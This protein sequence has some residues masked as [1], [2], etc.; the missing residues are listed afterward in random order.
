MSYGDLTSAALVRF[1]GAVAGGLV[2]LAWDMRGL[3]ALHH[4]GTFL[5]PGALVGAVVG[6]IGAFRR[7]RIM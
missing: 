6:A 3:A 1:L 2:V 4:R 7:R 5:L